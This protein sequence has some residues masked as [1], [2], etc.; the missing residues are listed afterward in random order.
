MDDASCLICGLN[1][2]RVETPHGLLY[3]DGLWVVRHMPPGFAGLVIAAIFAAA[4][5]TTPA[6]S[7]NAVA[8]ARKVVAHGRRPC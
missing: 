4:M 5:S 6:A 8:P 2:G 3:Q 1:H 7:Q